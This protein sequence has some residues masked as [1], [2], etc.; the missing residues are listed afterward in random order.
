M[1]LSTKLAANFTKNVRKR[2]DDYYCKGRVTIHEGS[3]SELTACVRGSG[4]YEVQFAWRDNKLAVWCDCPHFVEQGVPCKHVWATTLAADQHQYLTAAASADKLILDLDALGADGLDGRDYYD[5]DEELY[6]DD[7]SAPVLSSRSPAVVW[8]PAKPKPADWRKQL[9]EVFPPGHRAAWPSKLEILYVVDIAKNVHAGDLVLSLQ[10][11]NRNAN[12]S[13]SRPKI[14]S[15]RQGQIAQLP[16]SEDREILSSLPGGQSYSYSYGYAG[17]YLP[18]PE[19]P[20]LSPALASMLMPLVV[21]TGRCFLR[22]LNEPDNLLP[23]AWDEGGPWNFVLELH[24]LGETACTLAGFFQRGEER[25]EATFPALAT[26]GL[27]ITRDRVAPLANDTPIEWIIALRKQG[28]ISVPEKERD[29]FL[30]T[31]LCCPN[32]P[33]LRVPEELRYEEVALPAHP[34]LTI[35]KTRVPYRHER[36]DAKLCFAYEGRMFAAFDP[37]RGFFDAAGRRFIRRDSN[38]EKAAWA[39]LDQLG[40]KQRAPTY[41]DS[42]PRWELA[43][44]KLPR[45]VRSLVEAGWDIEAEGKIFRRPGP[46]RIEVSSGVDWFELHGE[47]EY[48]NTTARLPELLEALR[49]FSFGGCLADDMGV[50]KTAQVLAL[51]ESRRELRAAGEPVGPSLVVVPKS[52]VFN[53]KEEAARFTPQLRVL[54]HTGLER[55]G[56]DFAAYDLVLTTYGTLRRDAW[57]FKDAEFDYVVLD[58]AQVVK[59]AET[60]SSKAAR[61]LRG[62]HRLAVSGTPMENHL[63][64]LWTLFEF[65]NPGMLGAANAF[66]VVGGSMRNPDEETRRLL[67]HAL[68]PFFLRRTKEQVARELPSKTEQTVYCELEP[69][70]R[71]LYDQLRQHYR[72]SLLRRIETA[73]LAKSKIQVLEALLR[74]RQAACHPG[75]LDSKRSSDSSAKLD[76]LLEQL[77]EVLDEGHKAL[78]FSQFTSL[79]KILRARLNQDGILY[80]YLD[81]ATRDRQTRVERFQN[82]KD[83][84]LFLVSLK[85]GGLGLNLT[86]AEYVFILDPWWNPAV[87]AQ[88]VDRAHRI[89]QTRPVFTYRLIARDTVEEKVL[90]LQKTKRD[91]AAAIIGAENSMIRDLR[92][93][94][95]ALLLS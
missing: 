92:S 67:G 29:E 79:L 72:D 50:G 40:L 39:F 12:G 90:E 45:I 23:L 77:R 94:D 20:L 24:R 69:E 9:G 93:E 37:A 82:D 27:V 47:V 56:N 6:E 49:R 25:G 88:A 87:E 42:T 64:E 61:L 2:G 7:G 3:Q 18:I 74:L 28:S 11:R 53:W 31:L 16:L 59:N 71:K 15:M 21:R 33:P 73:G 46:F 48:G 22:P 5:G 19:S 32:L 13:F 86:A 34:H 35:S 10:S 76:V 54:D 68:R 78:V 63:G 57:S 83:C 17:T 85:A 84:R 60:E 95:L 14:L 91:L 58:E 30:A 8:N 65:L 75:L 1:S 41:P 38:A 51:L 4:F 81:G 66:K 70:Q 26:A 36:L 55:N 80:E 43:P 62:Q 44:S 89:G 52:L